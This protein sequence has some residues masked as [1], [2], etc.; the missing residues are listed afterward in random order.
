M[1]KL[2]QEQIETCLWD[3]GLTLQKTRQLPYLTAVIEE[4]MRLHMVVPVVYRRAIRAINIDEFTIPTGSQVGICY[5]A[6]A[7]MGPDQEGKPATDW[8][9]FHPERYLENNAAKGNERLTSAG[10]WSAP[11]F[12]GG[13]R[14]C[15]GMELAWLELRIFVSLFVKS[16]QWALSGVDKVQW[17]DVAT[18]QPI[19]D[20]SISLV[21]ANE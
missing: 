4:V 8:L 17:T 3:D 6:T 16:G 10:R 1:E 12:G 15:L 7:R 14:T 11:S 21:K 19:E 20:F 13:A 18:P 5:D 2:R 9:E